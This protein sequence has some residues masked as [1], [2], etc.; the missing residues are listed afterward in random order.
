MP[1]AAGQ[2]NAIVQAS[3]AFVT[4]NATPRRRRLGSGSVDRMATLRA[5]GIRGLVSG[6]MIGL[7]RS[8]EAGK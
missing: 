5:C 7:R 6:R 8:V 2:E 3:S 4:T 1:I